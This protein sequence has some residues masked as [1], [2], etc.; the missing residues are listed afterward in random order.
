MASESSGQSCSTPIEAADPSAGDESGQFDPVADWDNLNLPPRDAA[1]GVWQHVYEDGR[2]Y[3]LYK[4]GRYPM[5]N[6]DTEQL[7]EDMKHAMMME[8]T[9]RLCFQCS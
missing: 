2:R 8:L 5:P 1:T 9:V 4:K 6:D 3:H 7:R